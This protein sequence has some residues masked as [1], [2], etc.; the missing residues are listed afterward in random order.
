VSEALQEGETGRRG[1][2]GEEGDGTLSF[3]SLSLSSPP[4]RI[5]I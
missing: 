2:G 3:V 5:V 1:M 4:T